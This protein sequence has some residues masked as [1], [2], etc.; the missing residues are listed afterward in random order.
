MWT[1]L[2]LGEYPSVLELGTFCPGLPGKVWHCGVFY[3]IN[4]FF[5]SFINKANAY[6]QCMTNLA[7][8]MSHVAYKTQGPRGLCL[9]SSC[10]LLGAAIGGS[11]SAT[12]WVCLKR[13]PEKLGCANYP[14]EEPEREASALL[15]VDSRLWE[16]G[17]CASIHRYQGIPNRAQEDHIF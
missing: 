1:R 12:Y 17:A 13:L 3:E 9:W 10:S 11:L 14:Q 2:K 15:D 7:W 6:R 8:H 16:C 4:S 5:F